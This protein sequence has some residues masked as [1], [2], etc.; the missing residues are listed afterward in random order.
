M[1]KMTGEAGD[2]AKSL[3]VPLIHQLS[4]HYVNNVI[5]NSDKL[6]QN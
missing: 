5:F 1:L 3:A 4:V 6:L 2:D